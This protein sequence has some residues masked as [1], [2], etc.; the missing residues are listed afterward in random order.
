MKNTIRSFAIF[1]LLLAFA[2]QASGWV[3]VCGM[4][5]RSAVEMQAC[6]MDKSSAVG[7]HTSVLV[8]SC[9]CAA[10]ACADVEDD[11]QAAMAGNGLA[12]KSQGLV[13]RTSTAITIYLTDRS[14]AQTLACGER[15][16][17]RSLYLLNNSLLI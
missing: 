11:V 14:A 8:S 10:I 5:E 9:C 17:P 16:P 12:A 1:Y 15:S 7:R 4:C 13:G 6:H 2:I 3:E